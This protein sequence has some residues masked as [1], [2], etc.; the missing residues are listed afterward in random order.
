MGC[1]SIS[2]LM[3]IYNEQA[4]LRKRIR[5][6]LE[7]DYEDYELII[8]DN[9]SDDATQGIVQEFAAVDRRI[10]YVRHERNIG[11]N[12][13]FQYLLDMASGDYVVFAGGHDMWSTNYIRLLK[14]RLDA[15]RKVCIAF[16]STVRIDFDDNPIPKKRG[17]YCTE[18]VSSPL[19]RFNIYMWAD[20]NPVYGMMRRVC[21]QQAWPDEKY[22]AG[23]LLFLQRMAIIGQFSYVSDA[24]FYRRE[25]REHETR[26]QRLSRYKKTLFKEDIDIRKRFWLT[27]F[28]IIHAAGTYSVP[29][30]RA[31]RIRLRFQLIASSLMAFIRFWPNLWF[32]P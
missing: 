3:P 6:I 26:K 15:N 4:W 10:E 5:S 1:P 28:A 31:R 25:N 17:I 32:R 14:E 11:A 29:G 20:Q 16:G 12:A 21:A 30:K 24:V 19:R 22:G 13:N 18:G 23:G 8:G 27:A 9:D 7:Q 2:I